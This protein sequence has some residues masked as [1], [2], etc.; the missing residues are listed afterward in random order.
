MWSP[1]K[2]S[3]LRSCTGLRGHRK[4]ATE[5]PD[6]L[7]SCEEVHGC[8]TVESVTERDAC[9]RK[10]PFPFKCHMAESGE[11]TY[12]RKAAGWQRKAAESKNNNESKSW[13]LQFKDETKQ[14]ATFVQLAAGAQEAPA[15]PGVM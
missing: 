2:D 7:K 3:K 15:A 1:P 12:S 8:I 13:H 14:R 10:I 11:C 6:V 5:H 4:V 9:C